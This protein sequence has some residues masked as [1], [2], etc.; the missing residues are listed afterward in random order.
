MKLIY[1]V[2]ALAT[3]AMAAPASPVEKRVLPDGC[4]NVYWNTVATGGGWG[5]SHAI[6][7]VCEGYYWKTEPPYW[8][9]N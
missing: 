9:C 1:T 3:L 6:N 5:C 2:L 4:A 8:S 7:D